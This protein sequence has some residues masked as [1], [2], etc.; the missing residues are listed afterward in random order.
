M[1]KIQLV[2]KLQKDPLDDMVYLTFTNEYNVTD[3]FS[4]DSKLIRCKIP[5]KLGLK[6]INNDY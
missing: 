1:D 6:E 3:I 4:I 5:S 2:I